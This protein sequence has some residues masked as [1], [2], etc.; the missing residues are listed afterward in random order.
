M[1]TKSLQD[2]WMQRCIDLAK[3]GFR[4]VK[5]NPMVGALI[6]SGDQVIGEGYHKYFGGPHAEINAINAVKEHQKHL[7]AGSTL[8]VTLEPCSHIGKTPPCSHR[9]VK[10]KIAQVIIGC[11]DPNP[12]VAGK[13]IQYLRDHH[14]NIALSQRQAECEKLISKF[15]ANVIGLPY[16]HLKWAQS[17][18][19]FMASAQNSVWLSN[20]FAGVLT[21]QY[22]S[23]YDAILVGKNTIII[24]NPQLTTR[25]VPGENPIRIV[26]DSFGKVPSTA[27]VITDQNPTLVINT[28]KDEAKGQVTYIKV[29]DMQD[30]D[31]TL[32][33]LFQKGI[34]SIVVEGGSQVLYSFINAGLWHEAMIIQTKHKL[35]EGIKAPILTGHL[36][37]KYCLQDDEIL[38]ISNTKTIR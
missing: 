26:L 21:H 34:T 14:I 8:Y 19:H 25:N 9:I 6:A 28:L 33:K 5:S 3:L 22:R 30:L 32:R 7:I 29:Q 18:D 1:N 4:G 20:A 13:G 23:Q 11:V 15:K 37:E 38:I 17:A 2:V 24:D 36:V 12:L 35:K 16:I 27:R 10:E 31:T